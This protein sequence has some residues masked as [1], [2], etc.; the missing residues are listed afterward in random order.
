MAEHLGTPMAAPA[1]S[2][3][4]V[5]HDELHKRREAALQELEHVDRRREELHAII[6]GCSGGIDAMNARQQQAEAKLPK[7][8]AP[9]PTPGPIGVP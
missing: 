1:P 6:E 8:I 2:E 9:H 3:D 5:F 4:A 7:S